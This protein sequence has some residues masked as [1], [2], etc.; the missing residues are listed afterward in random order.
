M[1]PRNLSYNVANIVLIYQLYILHVRASLLITPNVPFCNIYQP[2]VT[3]VTQNM[4]TSIIS[5]YTSRYTQVNCAKYYD[6]TLTSINLNE[7][8]TIEMRITITG[9]KEN[10]MPLLAYRINDFPYL[11]YDMN[12]KLNFTWD[13][14]DENGNQILLCIL[15]MR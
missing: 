2:T 9:A 13:G 4:S 14:Y 8:I 10:F 6:Y 5:G 3:E 12:H 15:M 1:L 11:Y 7:I